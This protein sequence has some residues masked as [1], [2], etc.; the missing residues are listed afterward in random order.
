MKNGKP[1]W[2]KRRTDVA[3][4]YSLLVPAFAI[5]GIVIFYPIIKGIVMSFFQYTFSF[6]LFHF[7][8]ISFKFLF[9]PYRPLF[10]PPGTPI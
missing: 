6:Y 9:L 8:S 7:L 10:V 4:A 3:F 2:N 5:L 1:F